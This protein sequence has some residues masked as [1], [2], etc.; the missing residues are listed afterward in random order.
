MKKP[1][2]PHGQHGASKGAGTRPR[3]R[4][5]STTPS[6]EADARHEDL[7]R[8]VDAHAATFEALLD[9]MPSAVLVIAQ[10]GRVLVNNRE[11]QRI[12]GVSTSD[13]PADRANWAQN[14]GLRRLDGTL[15][16]PD[17]A[18]SARA[19]RGETVRDAEM[20]IRSSQ[21]PEG[22][23][24][25]ANAQP[26]YDTE[27]RQFGA[28][29]VFTD[30]NERKRAEVRRAALT[31]ALAESETRFR[32][33]ADVAPVGIWITSAPGVMEYA[34]PRTL[35]ILGG[36]LDQIQPAEWAAIVHPEDLAR[37][38]VAFA[39]LWEQGT[40]Y[41]LEVRMCKFGATGP[42]RWH[43]VCAV[44]IRDANGRTLRTIGN[45]FD[46]DDLK[47]AHALAEAATRMKSEFLANMSHEIRTPMNAIIGMSSLLISTGLTPEQRE[48]A[49]I[50]RSSGDHLLTVIN[51]ILDFSKIEA[52]RLTLENTRFDLR[53]CVEEA[54]DFVAVA[55]DGK[56]IEL[57]Y[58]IDPR[59]PKQFQGDVGRIRQV[60]VNLLSNAVKFTAIGE[61]MLSVDARLLAEPEYELE[62]SVRDTGIGIPLDRLD[63]LFKVF[64]QVDASTTRQFGGTGLGLA[65]SQRL[66]SLM[67]GRIG[68]ESVPGKGSTFRFSIRA[69]AG[70]AAPDMLRRP[71][72]SLSKKRL[73]AVD[74]N[75]TNLKIVRSYCEAWGMT[76][77]TVEHPAEA[78]ALLENGQTFD[79]A[80][81][82]HLMPDMDGFTLGAKIRQTRGGTHLPLVLLSSGSISRS[83]LTSRAPR[84]S[85]IVGKPIKPAG[86]QSAVMD[87]LS[88]SKVAGAH[89]SEQRQT[90][91]DANM[92]VWHPLRILLVEDNAVNQRVA[93]MLLGKL[94]YTAD[95]AGNGLE[96]LGAIER[97]TY[98]LV[99]MDVQMPEMDGLDATRHACRRWPADKRPHIVGMTANATDQDRLDCM[100]AGMDDYVSKPVTVPRLVD[101]L[102]RCPRRAD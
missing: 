45:F 94:G 71:S 65:I 9:S 76:V 101:S 33:I 53:L 34:N 4:A 26:V 75:P 42:Y 80:V 7:Q 79:V 39:A 6:A 68:V 82:D 97:Q 35:E 8:Q 25:Q 51:E 102:Q 88:S 59:V 30:I 95:L 16:A 31:A 14:Y 89:G 90:T 11:A 60:L 61:V 52:G 98:D 36:T 63:R 54:I 47:Q 92:G 15:F 24:V 27:G 44:A 96:A 29:V 74:D 86:L 21:R 100:Q 56:R 58:F 87:A 77:E 2:G 32:V 72:V 40:T 83:E 70:D 43:R 64:S 1:P 81:L 48:Y 23:V 57:A 99:F 28:I 78:L 67:G 18:P 62:F 69:R 17:E 38:A 37:V 3:K 22:I 73:L 66:V 55:A 41:D 50:L 93:R 10:D 20:L 84:F 12:S 46:I 19:L 91:F 85:V 49:N 13:L 5:A